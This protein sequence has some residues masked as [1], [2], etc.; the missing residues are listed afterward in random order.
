MLTIMLMLLPISASGQVLKPMSAPRQSP[1]QPIQMMPQ[2]Q[3]LELQM[4]EPGAPVLQG[5]RRSSSPKV[6]YKRPAGAFPGF[7][8]MGTEDH[9]LVGYYQSTTLHVAPVIPYTYKGVASGT[10]G[11]P[12]FCW[13]VPCYN[14]R[15]GCV[16]FV[17]I[18]DKQDISVIYRDAIY[19]VPT[20]YVSDVDYYSYQMSANIFNDDGTNQPVNILP[21]PNWSLANNDGIELLK[22]STDFSYVTGV[23]EANYAF[24]AY[25]GLTPY[26]NNDEGYWFG[27]NAGKGGTHVDGFGQAFEKP[28]HPYLLKEVV[29]YTLGLNVT[30]NVDMRCKIYRINELPDYQDAACVVLPE[31]PG[32]LIAIGVAHL[33]PYQSNDYYSLVPFTLY[34]PDDADVSLLIERP[35]TID[36]AILVVIDG[37]NDP[38]MSGLV[39][40]TAMIGYEYHVDDGYGERA[41]IKVGKDDDSGHFDGHYQWVGLNNVFSIGEM[42]TGISIFLTTD[43]PFLVSNYSSDDYK[44]TFPAAGGVMEK[45]LT[46]ENGEDV[47]VSSIEIASWKS[48]SSGEFGFTCNGDDLPSWLNIFATDSIT[49]GE[50]NY[51]INARVI[52]QPLEDGID[53]REAVV[54][55]A[56]PGTYMDYKLVQ[57]RQGGDD[58]TVVEPV[59]P[60]CLDMPNVI[61]SAGDTVMMP[62]SM[63]NEGPVV[64][65]QTYIKLPDGFELVSEDGRYAITMSD[66]ASADHTYFAHQLPDGRIRVSCYSPT[67]T[68]FEGN[69][70]EL[71]Y[72]PVR[73]PWDASGDYVMQLTN[74]SFTLD[75]FSEWDVDAVTEAII[76]VEPAI[77]PCDVNGDGEITVADANTVII[78]IINGGGNGNGGHTRIPGDGECLEGDVNGDGEVN[79]ADVNAIIDMILRN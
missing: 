76:S 34:T 40:F 29:L 79:I 17:R 60:Y 35:I 65:L 59:E 73:V 24:M 38:E 69:T 71:F 25:G 45:T 28:E 26:G 54:R 41:Y 4:R 31:N 3:S 9:E 62:V 5:P 22:S 66:R 68:P 70:G 52:A 16:D 57:S 32:E 48:A 2:V 72:L 23:N 33:R 18:D 53:Y 11:E 74:T 10:F 63:S 78:I 64:A 27:K 75:D 49:D 8:A 37:Y 36:D 20:M 7:I 13:D 1:L 14:T 47:T 12:I 50:Y 15:N 56:I 42:K 43:L 55:F 67:Q 46:D 19:D 44:Y 30:A 61:V 77:D 21:W 6:Y 39:N 58:T 51:L